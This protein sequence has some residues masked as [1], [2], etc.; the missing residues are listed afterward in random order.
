MFYPEYKS[1]YDRSLYMNPA[2]AEQAPIAAIEAAKAS[3]LP[4]P[5]L[6]EARNTYV[7]VANRSQLFGYLPGQK[8]RLD[9]AEFSYQMAWEANLRERLENTQ[10][11]GESLYFDMHHAISTE[12]QTRASAEQDDLRQRKYARFLLRYNEL[13]WT[14]KLGIGVVLGGAS[15]VSMAA[16]GGAAAAVGASLAVRFGSIHASREARR[17]SASCPNNSQQRHDFIVAGLPEQ[18]TPKKLESWIGHVVSKN[19]AEYNVAGEAKKARQSLLFSLG[20]IAIGRGLA[21]ASHLLA[22]KPATTKVQNFMKDK[23]F[24][25]RFAKMAIETPL[26]TP[27]PATQLAS[28][29]SIQ[30]KWHTIKEAPEQLWVRENRQGDYRFFANKRFNNVWDISKQALRL[31]GAKKP[32]ME[33]ISN[34]KNAV[35]EQR[36]Q[37]GKSSMLDTGER[38]SVSRRL[39][40]RVLARKS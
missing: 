13:H 11:E 8:Q 3:P 12:N 32:S 5:T 21:E 34:L 4:L 31:N 29:S 9:R 27:N 40:N 28:E 38:V 36:L 39:I 18:A 15:A 23:L 2:I 17:L 25:S 22:D 30:R 7:N 14:K 33:Q 16:T 26:S 35:V 20:G 10:L 19:L 24:A 37:N 1:E 6:E